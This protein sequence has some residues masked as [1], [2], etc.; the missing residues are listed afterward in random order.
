LGTPTLEADGLL[1]RPWKD[2]DAEAI[3]SAFQADREIP[4]RTGFPFGLAVDQ[5]REYISERRRGWEA[6]QKAAF[7]IFDRGDHLLG[8]ISLLEIDWHRREAEVAFWLA[9]EARGRGVT[10]RALDESHRGPRSFDC[11]ASPRPWR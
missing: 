3:A 11:R 2:L 1:L 9:R 8:S 6:G 4:R 10:T 7:G 5:A